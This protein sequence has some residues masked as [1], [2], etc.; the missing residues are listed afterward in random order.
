MPADN[1]W[2]WTRISHVL[3]AKDGE[4]HTSVSPRPPQA[5]VTNHRSKRPREPSAD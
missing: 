1:V 3:L 5:V 4:A 2:K